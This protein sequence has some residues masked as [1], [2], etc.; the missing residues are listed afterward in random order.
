MADHGSSWLIMA[1]HGS[2]WLIM[3][4]GWLM[5]YHGFKDPSHCQAIREPYE[6]MISRVSS[7]GRYLSLG[8][9]KDQPQRRKG[10]TWKM[11]QG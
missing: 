11:P 4:D 9:K 10:Q 6:D 7:F 3:A 2:S 1:H 8:A 5:A